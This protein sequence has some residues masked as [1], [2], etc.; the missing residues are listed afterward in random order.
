LVVEQ[1]VMDQDIERE[2]DR[3][4]GSDSE[5]DGDDDGSEDDSDEEDEDDADLRMEN[6]ALAVEFEAAK[7]FKLHQKKLLL[8][9]AIKEEE[10]NKRKRVIGNVDVVSTDVIT[11]D[12]MSD[13]STKRIK[14][15]VIKEI[16]GELR[17]D[18][19]RQYILSVGG[20]IALKELAMV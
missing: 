6:S 13:S 17:D 18:D 2:A 12:S 4:I 3:V 16:E 20:K 1:A 14:I 7:E 10:S 11:T 19:V 9:G 5:L 15:E 8:E